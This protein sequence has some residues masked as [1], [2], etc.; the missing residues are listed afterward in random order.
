[1]T[2]E[3]KFTV[4]DTNTLKQY[5]IDNEICLSKDLSDQKSFNKLLYKRF[6]EY[7]IHFIRPKGRKKTS[8]WEKCLKK[9]MSFYKDL[10]LIEAL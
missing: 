3:C 10:F 4:V 2:L 5:T 7:S 6:K 1:M 9:N 8:L